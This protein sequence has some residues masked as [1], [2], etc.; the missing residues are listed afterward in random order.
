MVAPVSC[1]GHGIKGDG[2]A[3][4]CPT[5]KICCAS[6]TGNETCYFGDCC[7]KSTTNDDTCDPCYQCVSVNGGYLNATWK[8]KAC[9]DVPL[10]QAVPMG[11]T[12][13][14]TDNDC[15]GNTLKC[16]QNADKRVCTCQ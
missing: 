6:A 12:K 16:K 11:S 15:P 5:G 14:A 4:K 8:C 7:I 3:E 10:P 1:G 9:Y 13:C 2:T